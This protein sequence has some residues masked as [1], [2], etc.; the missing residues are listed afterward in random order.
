[1]NNQDD[2]DNL[3]EQETRRIADLKKEQDQ[4][5]A[6][7]IAAQ[8]RAEDVPIGESNVPSVENKPDFSSNTPDI[9]VKSGSPSTPSPI[10]QQENRSAEPP[11]YRISSS[12]IQP[13][14]SRSNIDLQKRMPSEEPEEAKVSLSG[15]MSSLLKMFPT[16]D[17]VRSVSRQAVPVVLQH[18]NNSIGA[19]GDVLRLGKAAAGGIVQA[20]WGKAVTAINNILTGNVQIVGGTGS[21]VTNDEANKTLT[22]SN[23][24]V[25]SVNGRTG[26]VK[27]RNGGAMSISPDAAS[28]DLFVE[29]IGVKSLSPTGGSPTTG[30]CVIQPGAGINTTN[31][32]GENGVRITNIGVHS[33]GGLSSAVGVISNDAS[34]GISAIGQNINFKNNGVTSVLAGNGITV[35]PTTGAVVVTSNYMPREHTDLPGET[36][37]RPGSDYGFVA[38]FSNLWLDPD[39]HIYGKFML[40]ACKTYG[41]QTL[42]DFGIAGTG[43]VSG[44]TS[45]QVNGGSVQTGAVVVNVQPGIASS[46]NGP[47]EVVTNLQYIEPNFQKK[48]KIITYTSGVVTN[49]S[50]ESGWV[51]ITVADICNT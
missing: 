3:A 2:Q 23:T 13:E 17:S 1:M 24:G 8:S 22:I 46:V 40:L 12:V 10:I 33:I 29:N 34:V 51:N 28:G 18:L 45:V 11:I 44:V 21:S 9:E 31:A 39:G 19:G 27:I 47:V 5:T 30:N 20:Y 37:H 16:L 6:E 41:G 36:P 26:D 43:A 7:F 35:S 32:I 4:K 15:L 14:P 25:I 42:F 48:T 38:G 50:A 49:I